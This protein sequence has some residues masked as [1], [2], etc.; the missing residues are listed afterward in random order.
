MVNLYIVN[1]AHKLRFVSRLISRGTKRIFLGNVA[2]SSQ[3]PPPAPKIKIPDDDVDNDLPEEKR[4]PKINVLDLIKKDLP[5]VPRGGLTRSA[6]YYRD[7]SEGGFVV[8][9]VEDTLFKVCFNIYSS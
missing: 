1:P 7:E 3:Y 4:L 2:A 6:E 9:R 5:P 8:F